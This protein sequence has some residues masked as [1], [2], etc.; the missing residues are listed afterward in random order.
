MASGVN[1]FPGLRPFEAADTHLFFGRD[2]QS[3]AVI[4]LLART[5]FVAVVGTSGSGKSSL[6]KAGLLPQLEGGLMASA[7]PNWRIALM[8]PGEHPLRHLARALA[9]RDVLGE[10]AEDVQLRAGQIEAV[11]RRGSHG[12]R[13]V[14]KQAG[15]PDGDNLL[16]VVDQFEELFRT[17]SSV[18]S[19]GSGDSA[20]FV[21]LLLEAAQQTVLPIYVV[22]TMRSDYLGD[23]ARFRGLAEA[24]NE[25]QYLV[26][27]MTREQ[28]RM[29]IEG[30]VAVGGARIAP[31]LVQQLLN[32]VGDQPDMLPVLQHA[33][34]RT[35]D[36]WVADG[37]ADAEID[38]AHYQRIGA[39]ELALSRHADEALKEAGELPQGLVIARKLFQRLCERATDYRETRR[40][41]SMSELAEVSGRKLADVISVVEVFRQPGRT[42][43]LP[44]RTQQ[45]EL[46]ADTVIDIAHEA[47]IRR[48][49]Q[50]G[51]W[52]HEEAEA[53]Q[54]YKR[55]ADDAVQHARREVP[56]WSG[57]LLRS[58]RRWRQRWQPTEAWARRYHL[59]FARAM[60]F[61]DLSLLAR[62]AKGLALALLTVV[63]LGLLVYMGATELRH[64][65]S[66]LQA[67]V[68]NLKN[69]EKINELERIAQAQKLMAE[70][71]KREADAQKS[72]NELV[73]DYAARLTEAYTD[74][75]VQRDSARAQGRQALA[76]RL[77][78]QSL[79]DADA[80][81]GALLA[82]EAQRTAQNEETAAAVWEALKQPEALPLWA[83]SGVLR[84]AS[85]S[86]GGRTVTIDVKGNLRVWSSESGQPLAARDEL[87]RSPTALALSADG[88]VIATAGSRSA[89]SLLRLR[90]GELRDIEAPAASSARIFDV[91]LSADGRVALTL[92]DKRHVA[93]WSLD[94]RSAAPL[95][96]GD[97]VQGPG[98]IALDQQGRWAALALASQLR[99]HDA[100]TGAL[101]RS[102]TL[103]GNVEHLLQLGDDSLLLRLPNGRLQWRHGSSFEVEQEV[104]LPVG[105]TL[106][107]LQAVSPTVIYAVIRD[108]R[109]V[110]LTVD[111]GQ[112]NVGP[113]L[114]TY[115]MG[116]GGSRVAAGSQIVD[117]AESANGDRAAMLV[118]TGSPISSRVDA[119]LVIFD[120]SDPS[121]ALVR[122]LPWRRMGATLAFA[123]SGRQLLL[124]VRAG[125]MRLQLSE[126]SLWQ[127]AF[128]LQGVRRMLKL[129][130]GSSSS[131]A[132][133][134]LGDDQNLYSAAQ[135]NAVPH[136]ISA[137]NVGKVTNPCAATL[138][139]KGAHALV[140][141]APD[142]S[143][144]VVSDA[145]E[146]SA[147]AKKADRGLA[148]W[149]VG[150]EMVALP[151]ARH[152]AAEVCAVSASSAGRLV[153]WAL[154]PGDGSQGA[155]IEIWDTGRRAL[156]R[157]MAV[158][159]QVK[160]LA[161]TP[162]GR[163]LV[164]AVAAAPGNEADKGSPAAK[165]RRTQVRDPELALKVWE[166]GAELREPATWVLR[167]SDDT[168]VELKFGPAGRRLV[169][170]SD[171][172][173]IEA[174]DLYSED[175]RAISDRPLPIEARGW[176]LSADDKL[177]VTFDATRGLLLH[178]LGGDRLTV[179]P[180]PR[181]LLAN[182]QR[183]ATMAFSPDGRWLLAGAKTDVFVWEVAG[184]KPV[185]RLRAV[186]LRDVSLLAFSSDS[187]VAISAGLGGMVKWDL[188][189]L[190][191][192]PGVEARL[193]RRVTRNLTLAAWRS[194]LKDQPYRLTCPEVP[195]AG[196]VYDGLAAEAQQYTELGQTRQAREAV[197]QLS[198]LVEADRELE[199]LSE[200]GALCR[201]AAL[202]GAGPQALPLCRAARR[203][204]PEDPEAAEGLAIAL[205]L[206]GQNG[207]AGASLREALKNKNYPDERRSKAQSWLRALDSGSN[208]FQP[209]VLRLL[210]RANFE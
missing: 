172:E 1:P 81:A 2:G 83:H 56:L 72:K 62:N 166:I 122:R 30:P 196:D 186:G 115:N 114:N 98:A 142:N 164:A 40:R 49:Q 124:G 130:I 150:G 28:R 165:A 80:E 155:A 148:W 143:G 179:R 64:R 87:H 21:A 121:A 170:V 199:S 59:G 90:G 38:L 194:Y 50:L 46:R 17:G 144:M 15:V 97:P 177:L 58:G 156:V 105:S 89:P 188:Q 162:D 127:G 178:M 133:L 171:A 94:E 129:A 103:P 132:L 119:Q 82:L 96:L 152:A 134:A 93:L 197:A 157:T 140:E 66:L 161:L 138:N 11:L 16:I 54:L 131:P 137:P 145:H 10:D 207:A 18:G 24:L 9:A 120:R 210:R 84:Q 149:P 146:S 203:L 34:M 52:V 106:L 65:H 7:G 112:L 193:C 43:L 101:K 26:P 33:L 71:Q 118:T 198:Q 135:A 5:R 32:D 76:S 159:G 75:Q 22:L 77:A 69:A 6:V 182:D 78:V 139:E 27:R 125:V 99:I 100:K 192:L 57:P 48:W 189:A 147:D 39:L 61:L 158:Q 181:R 55:L 53:A 153:A 117:V 37:K 160:A 204:E 86:G 163:R 191:R 200:S 47:L 31:R 110:R 126:P 195:V 184:A 202:T 95:L 116:S 107:R 168:D 169:V 185:A 174:I 190:Q 3:T 74:A 60:R 109:A 85:I 8:T 113:A 209:S 29:A 208:P 51:E 141:N 12:L 67:E 205:A 14:M 36:Q 88:N 73:T 23:C 4:A 104:N 176:A 128:A 20:D 111:G 123:D 167:G 108:G 102:I 187:R 63:P 68:Q 42:F 136:V 70:V 45:P 13:E 79:L 183:V 201:N 35:W 25:G 92:D 151:V 41:T 206:S 173:Q 91:R 19:D 154:R 180:E 175:G 44:S